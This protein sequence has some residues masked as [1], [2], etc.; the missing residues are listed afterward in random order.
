MISLETYNKSEL[1]NLVESEKYTAFPFCPISKHRAISHINNPRASDNDTLLILIY[2]DNRLAG[3]MGI[4]PDIM[5]LDS[6]RIKVGWLST[7]YVDPH[8]RGK[9]L[10]QL[11]LAK[12]S[13]DYNNYVIITEYTPEAE[14][15]YIKS[16]LFTSKVTVEGTSF[17]YRSNLQHILPTKNSKWNSLSLALKSIDSILNIYSNIKYKLLTRK[18]NNYHI[19]EKLDQESK[20][21]IEKSGKNGTFNRKN[22][23]LEW[24]SNYPWIEESA[25]KIDLNYQFSSYAREFKF[26]F[27]KVYNKKNLFAVLMI[28]IRNK[29]A[30][31][32]HSFA[33]N[34]QKAA[35]VLHHCMIKNKIINL[36][37]FDDSINEC[38]HNQ[39]F[40]FKKERER[41]FM[42]HADLKQT[43]EDKDIIEF[44][45]GDGDTLFT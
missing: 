14:R 40:L 29:T 44:K 31:L 15:M 36:I 21:F 5:Q 17:Y 30:K 41:H 45:G 33:T 26:I 1:Q 2:Y 27:I 19:I 32:L 42:Y 37:S 3:Y 35:K 6:K 16:K 39:F 13:E 24:V 11:L 43:I 4:L 38:L 25:D 20:T 12:A 22:R 8:Y 34:H 18:E 28:S 7:L 23:E 9:R 10:G